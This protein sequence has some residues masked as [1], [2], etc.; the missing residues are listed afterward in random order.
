MKL[1]LLFCRFQNTRR[2]QDKMAE[3][4]NV[5]KHC[6]FLGC[7]QLDFLPVKCNHCKNT[8]CKEHF[9]YLNHDCE[10]W[11]SI[12]DNNPSLLSN[13]E[14]FYCKFAG[15]EKYE[16]TPIVCPKCDQNF[17]MLHR[18]EK[19]HECGYK[20]PEHMPK[21]AVIVNQIVE[22]NQSEN[23]S[24]QV[25][26]PKVLSSKAQKIAAK[27]Q[28]MKLKQSAIGNKSIPL[29]DRIHFRIHLPLSKIAI[30][31]GPDKT[32]GVFVNKSSGFGKVL[33]TISDLCSVVNQNN[34]GGENAKKLRLFKHSTGEILMTD[35]FNVTLG[36]L[37][38]SEQV[39][40]GE[41]LV[42]EYLEADKL[43]TGDTNLDLSK[44]VL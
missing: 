30:M 9:S 26:K 38:N 1:L 42:L 23:R 21:T 8:F 10:S 19:D 40:N 41:T 27:V 18:L 28:L 29:G 25:K 12:S 37:L 16:T 3:L 32:K 35:N 4:L 14:K 20:K 22:K 11:K 33:D 36:D 15:C 44:Y 7:N 39:L 13:L 5:G 34:V 43:Q 24:K 6:G 17:C 31:K 2:A